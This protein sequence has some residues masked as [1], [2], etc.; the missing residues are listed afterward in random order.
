MADSTR[1]SGRKDRLGWLMVV[2]IMLAMGLRVAD[3]Q[4]RP[5]HFDEAIN[6]TMG[7]RSPAGVL[8]LSR[9][10][11]DNDPPGHRFALGIWMALAGPSPLAIRIF[12][13]FF[14]LL[15]VA[16]T[17]RVSREMRLGIWPSLAAAGLLAI[18]PYAIDYAQ[19]AKG[20]AMGI[21]MAML[22]WWMWLRL[23]KSGEPAARR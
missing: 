14:G 20:Y 23:F 7:Q 17:Y 15:A 3:L 5:L 18:S 10:T 19:Q 21:G 1:R 11:F 8:S 2:L 13:V 22:S 6:V 12:S 4:R 16:L 9:Q